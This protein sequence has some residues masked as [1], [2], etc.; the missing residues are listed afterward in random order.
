[1]ASLYSSKFVQAES[2]KIDGDCVIFVVR[3]CNDQNMFNPDSVKAIS[4]VLDIIREEAIRVARKDEK[5]TR[6]ALVTT[7]QGKFYSTGLQLRDHR[8]QADLPGFLSKQYLPLMGKLLVFPMVSVAAINGHAFAGG[9]VMA[10][11]HDFRVMRK[12]RG[13]LCMNE[14]ELPSPVPAGMAA[15]IRTKFSNPSVVRDCLLEAKRFPAEEAL[16][17]GII[18]DTAG[19]EQECLERAIELAKMKARA[20]ALF[21]ITESIKRDLYPEAIQLLEKP[22]S[23]KHV[24]ELI[25]KSKL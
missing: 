7:G 22:D 15:V 4:E 13:F 11:S 2:L 17:L 16:E 8:V 25:M 18:D 23:M 14:I 9:M 19:D 5:V 24:P 12:G 20:I 21:P 6:A 1:M 10:M 3:F